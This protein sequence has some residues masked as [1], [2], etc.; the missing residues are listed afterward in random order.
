MAELQ[1][2]V[3]L[4]GDDEAGSEPADVVGGARLDGRAGVDA[5][6][7]DQLFEHADGLKRSVIRRS[8]APS[9]H[10]SKRERERVAGLSRGM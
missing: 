4:D 10:V 6:L 2:G 3:S 8:V 5:S 1:D 7:R 9:Y